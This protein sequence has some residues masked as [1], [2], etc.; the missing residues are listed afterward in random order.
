LNI[1]K[2]TT[3]KEGTNNSTKIV[4]QIKLRFLSNRR[5]CFLILCLEENFENISEVKYF[6]IKFLVSF[7]YLLFEISSKTFSRVP[8][9]ICVDSKAFGVL[10]LI[11]RLLAFLISFFFAKTF[12]TFL[13]LLFCKR[14]T[15]K[16]KQRKEK[17][18]Q[19]NIMKKEKKSS[20]SRPLLFIFF[21]L[22]MRLGEQQC[23]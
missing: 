12:T 14:S 22:L 7:I 9:S 16:Q 23:C 13:M 21:Y 2:Q 17:F 11:L 15:N 18:S 4:L 20:T 3:E 5:F 10:L 8:V 1:R 6:R 19:T